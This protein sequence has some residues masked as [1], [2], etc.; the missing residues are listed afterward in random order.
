MALTMS[1]PLE[2][3][4][5][6]MTQSYEV[7]LIKYHSQVNLLLVKKSIADI[8]TLAK[9]NYFNSSMESIMVAQTSNAQG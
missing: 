4:A 1:H 2:N 5:T 7:H 6:R 9:T 3:I 8:E